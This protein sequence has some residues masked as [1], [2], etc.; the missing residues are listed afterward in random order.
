MFI[1]SISTHLKAN[2]KGRLLQNV[3]STWLL[4][5]LD[6]TR[7]LSQCINSTVMIVFWNLAWLSTG[8]VK[9]LILAIISKDTR[10]TIERWTFDIVLHDESTGKGNAGRCTSNLYLCLERKLL[11]KIHSIA[12]P[13]A[14]RNPN[15]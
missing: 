6:L 8:S 9:G 5:L 15:P 7:V 13:K 1:G 4:A 11:K 10:T 12:S 2:M 3:Q 14:N